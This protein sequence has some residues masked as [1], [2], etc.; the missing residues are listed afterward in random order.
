MAQTKQKKD[1]LIGKISHYYS[2]IGVAVIDLTGALKVGDSIRIVGGENTD[3]TQEV[4]SME[5][6]RKKIKTAKSGSS[7]GL[8]IKEKAREDYKVYKV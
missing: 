5:I 8:K 3:F 7:I 4:D 6:D 2:N 1:K